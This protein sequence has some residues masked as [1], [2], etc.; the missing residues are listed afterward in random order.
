MRIVTRTGAP[1]FP[2]GQLFM[3]SAKC[4]LY[5]PYDTLIGCIKSIIRV[6]KFNGGGEESDLP[7]NEDWLRQMVHISS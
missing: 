6:A 3:W 5:G 2:A 4:R 1:T 7:I